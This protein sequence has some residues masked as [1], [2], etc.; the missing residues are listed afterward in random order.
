MNTRLHGHPG[1][2]RFNKIERAF[3]CGGLLR[4]ALASQNFNQWIRG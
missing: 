3:R 2:R 4:Q 1:G